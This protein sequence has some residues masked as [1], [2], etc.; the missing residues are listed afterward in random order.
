MS[1]QNDDEAPVAASDRG[2]VP[3]SVRGTVPGTCSILTSLQPMEPR[4]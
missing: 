4:G 1:E 2:T 3:E